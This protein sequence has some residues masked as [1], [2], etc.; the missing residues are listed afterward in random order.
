MTSRDTSRLLNSW[1]KEL[2]II[3]VIT[4]WLNQ[5]FGSRSLSI[6]EVT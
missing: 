2:I 3:A 6:V 1:F 5:A 4:A